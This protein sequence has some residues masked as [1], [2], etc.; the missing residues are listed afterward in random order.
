MGIGIL[1]GILSASSFATGFILS[2]WLNNRSWVRFMQEKSAA[3]H[4]VTKEWLSEQAAECR[5]I[6]KD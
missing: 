1:V 6:R 3:N 5:A 2:N 4:L